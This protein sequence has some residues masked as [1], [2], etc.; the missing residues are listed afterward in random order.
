MKYN[1]RQEDFYL[2]AF[3]AFKPI[4]IEVL[5]VERIP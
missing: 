2:P 4:L 5:G 1:P 3:L